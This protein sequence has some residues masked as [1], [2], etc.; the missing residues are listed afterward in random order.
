MDVNIQI[1]YLKLSTDST[2]ES[3]KEFINKRDQFIYIVNS[4]FCNV[5]TDMRESYCQH[6]YRRKWRCHL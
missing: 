3:L 2:R 4:E 1:E 6:S 5:L